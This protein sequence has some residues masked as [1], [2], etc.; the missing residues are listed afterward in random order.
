VVADRFPVELDADSR[1]LIEGDV[2]VI[3]SKGVADELL[4]GLLTSSSKL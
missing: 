4:E 3:A 2:A 1:C